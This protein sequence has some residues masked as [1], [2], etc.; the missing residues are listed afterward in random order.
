MY[1]HTK[2]MTKGYYGKAQKLAVNEKERRVNQ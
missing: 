2:T 1:K